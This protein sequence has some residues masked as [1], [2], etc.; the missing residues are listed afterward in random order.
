MLLYCS[1]I[2]YISSKSLHLTGLPRFS[3][4]V[5]H[6]WEY[7]VLG[8]VGAGAFCSAPFKRRIALGLLCAWA[9]SALY[10]LSD[11]FHQSFVPGRVASLW[12]AL[13]DAIG[14]GAGVLVAR[15]AFLTKQKS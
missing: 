11:E 13:A 2:F 10:G 14:G 6:F 3:D 5:V 12:D 4:K 15:W 8:M 9:F 7:A 1:L